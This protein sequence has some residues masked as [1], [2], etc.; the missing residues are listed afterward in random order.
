LGYWS[1]AQS[2][3]EFETNQS[4][5]SIREQYELGLQDLQAGR[6][7]VARQRLDYVLSQDPAY[8]GATEKMVEVM[9]ILF[10]TAT[11]TALPATAT[12]TPTRDIR[13]VQ[14]LFSQAQ[15]RFASADWSGTLDTLSALRKEDRAYQ[16]ARVDGMMF[17]ALRNRGVDKILKENNLE[18]GIYDLALAE[19]FG[20]IDVDADIARNWARL[21]IYGLS[22]WEVFPEQAVY[23][24]GQVAAAAPNLRDASGW[25]ASARYW[26]A[27]TQWGDQ[28]ARDGEWC[29]A[30]EKYELAQSMQGDGNLQATAAYA[31]DQCSPPTATPEPVTETPTPTLT[32][33]PTLIP[34]TQSSPTST[35]GLP[36]TQ[37]PTQSSSATPTQGLPVTP[38]ETPTPPVATPSTEIPP[39]GTTT[40]AAPMPSPTVTGAAPP[41]EATATAT[42]APT[43]ETSN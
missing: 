40:Q 9:Q 31:A 37:T 29:D 24:F 22:F 16:T 41:P 17:M 13:P 34:S 12:P 33:T 26:A 2:L 4:A 6:Y 1:G 11:P 5:L 38:T 36:P 14:E 3:R 35:Q 8:P 23:Y 42:T 21:Y 15:S 28:L 32:E 43:G 39:T 10:A 19:R 18:G 7:E 25:T 27:L 20:P 30:Q